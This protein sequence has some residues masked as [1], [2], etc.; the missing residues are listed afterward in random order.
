MKTLIAS[1]LVVVAC[2]AGVYAE[3]AEKP[4]FP[5][6]D[7][8]VLVILCENQYNEIQRLREEVEAL[9]AQIAAG[10]GGA[11]ATVS[12]DV[13]SIPNGSWVVTINSVT[14]P[15]TSPLEAEIVQLKQDLNGTSST[16][17]GG[18]QPPSGINHRLSEA[19]KKEQAVL[20]KGKYKKVVRHDNTTV[21]GQGNPSG[22]RDAERRE[23]SSAVTSLERQKKAA[24]RKI[25][26]LNRRIE[27]ERNAVTA[28]GMTDEGFPVT[29]SAGGVYAH[30]G[31]IL[32]PGKT[33]TV[34]GRGVFG[35]TSGEITIKTAA[36]NHA[37]SV[38]E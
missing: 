33:F 11:E 38:M 8:A 27:V 20:A 14:K 37:D 3:E 26:D 15:D 28:H 34:T 4:D 35:A 30:V 22:Y 2:A 21:V 1:V 10:H 9:K 16:G 25:L 12:G 24:E 36:E 23:A 18:Y 31:H 6:Y 13:T 32:E 19:R 7:K 29:L 5:S 17:A